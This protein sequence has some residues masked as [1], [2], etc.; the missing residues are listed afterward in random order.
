MS[1]SQHGF[2]TKT[3]CQTSVTSLCNRGIAVGE[4][5]KMSCILTAVRFLTLTCY[6]E[7][8]DEE[9]WARQK[10]SKGQ[11]VRLG[12]KIIHCQS[13]KMGLVRFYRDDLMSSLGPR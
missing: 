13:K 7:K 12:W 4:K 1:N 11:A 9:M 3:P 10:Y 5:D 2:V 6:F 8:A